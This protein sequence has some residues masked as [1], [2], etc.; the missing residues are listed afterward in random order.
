MDVQQYLAVVT[1]SPEVLYTIRH[2]HVGAHPTGFVIITDDIKAININ[3]S[4]CPLYLCSTDL[5]TLPGCNPHD[6]LLQYSKTDGD[7]ERILYILWEQYKNTFCES[8]EKSMKRYVYMKS[9]P[10]RKII[11]PCFKRLE[12]LDPVLQR[13]DMIESP[14]EGYKPQILLVEHSPFPEMETIATKYN[15]EW[16]W[17]YLEPR[18]PNV[19]IGQ[20]N[21]ALAYDKAFIFGSPAQWYL[22]HDNDVLVP[23]DFWSRLDANIARTGAQF[24]QPYTHRCLICLK[25]GPSEHMRGDLSLMDAPLVKDLYYDLTPGAPGGSLYITRQR[26][27]E[28]GGHDPNISWGYGPEDCLFW[29]KLQTFEPIAY[30]DDPPIELVHLWHTSAAPNNPFLHQM[31]WFVKVYFSGKTIE[32]KRAY[33][34]SKR[35]I[36][37]KLLEEKRPR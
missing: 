34:A 22:F 32:E 4:V 14:P 26:Y 28:V 1:E 7:L 5:Q 29:D 8:T 3:F 20:F 9:L 33:M 15:C 11:I 12:N 36:L 27:I 16:I 23:N 17:I 18:I 6:V 24:L 13:F 10:P 2:K 35:Q 37:E 30:A 31:N 21:K 25:P 19:P